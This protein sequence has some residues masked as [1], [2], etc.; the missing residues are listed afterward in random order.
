M[1]LQVLDEL[2]GA[3][4]DDFFT[5][6]GENIEFPAGGINTTNKKC[7]AIP[8]NLNLEKILVAAAMRR[9]VH[10]HTEGKKQEDKWKEVQSEVFNHALFR[11]YT[12]I[13]VKKKFDRL[14]AA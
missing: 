2:R 10:L 12:P 5:N 4:Y 6:E 8:W 14:M 1:N 9:N 7:K 11:A 13:D 3:A